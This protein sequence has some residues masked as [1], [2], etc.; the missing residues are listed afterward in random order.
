MHRCKSADS[1]HQ[2]HDLVETF[3]FYRSGYPAVHDGALVIGDDPEIGRPGNEGPG[4][5]LL[6]RV[7]AGFGD[8]VAVFHQRFM[9]DPDMRFHS[10]GSIVDIDVLGIIPLPFG[11]G[12]KIPL[13]DGHTIDARDHLIAFE[14]SCPRS[15]RA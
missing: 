2:P 1:S 10:V 8:Q 15:S 7:Q 13:P 5:P 4:N 3:S 12:D 11:M 9:A 6:E 14:G